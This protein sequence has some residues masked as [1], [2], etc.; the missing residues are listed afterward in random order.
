MPKKHVFQ[1]ACSHH[2]VPTETLFITSLHFL[3]FFIYTKNISCI[4]HFM[5]YW[6][7][8]FQVVKH[9]LLNVSPFKI[10]EL[11]K[12]GKKNSSPRLSCTVFPNRPHHHHHPPSPSHTPPFRPPSVTHAHSPLIGRLPQVAVKLGRAPQKRR[13]RASALASSRCDRGKKKKQTHNNDTR[14]RQD[15]LQPSRHLLISFHPDESSVAGS[16]LLD[17]TG[18]KVMFA[19]S[20]PFALPPPRPCCRHPPKSTSLPNCYYRVLFYKP[21]DYVCKYIL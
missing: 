19:S 8:F 7:F 14:R 10:D 6:S 20:C 16:Q 1:A 4:C 11:L 9:F 12:M 18:A 3:F 13:L 17:E 21:W 2:M 5:L 15:L